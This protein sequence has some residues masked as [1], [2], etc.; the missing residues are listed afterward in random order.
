MPKAKL[1]LDAADF[2]KLPY[3][4]KLANVNPDIEGAFKAGKEIHVE[5]S[6]R[7]PTQLVKL[8]TYMAGATEE[9]VKAFAAKQEALAA[10]KKA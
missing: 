3:A 1:V 6:Y 2:K 4:A 9:E 10:K 7:E 8:G 5:L